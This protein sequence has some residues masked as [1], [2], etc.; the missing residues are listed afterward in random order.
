MRKEKA[1]LFPDSSTPPMLGARQI[2][3]GQRA[4]FFS[5]F[6]AYLVMAKVPARLCLS[7]QVIQC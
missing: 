5:F 7:W 4:S 3:K 6:P 1:N 2:L